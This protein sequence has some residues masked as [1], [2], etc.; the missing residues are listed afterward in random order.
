[1]MQSFRYNNNNNGT[2]GNGNY[3]RPRSGQ[4]KLFICKY[5]GRKF[6]N[7]QA[8]GGH[9][10]A[11]RKEREQAKHFHQEM[12]AMARFAVPSIPCS[13]VEPHGLEHQHRFITEA[14][15]FWA[16]SGPS[17]QL[18]TQQCVGFWPRSYH[19]DEGAADFH[20]PVTIN[21]QRKIAPD[22]TEEEGDEEPRPSDYEQRR[23]LELDQ[24]SELNLDL[25]L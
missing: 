14:E 3:N 15:P 2:G 16:G 19:L 22:N 9:Q 10:N 21:H 13:F 23:S 4:F 6:L 24:M 20:S 18:S 8:L 11:H 17:S 7:S 12:M 1:M 25:H 5:C